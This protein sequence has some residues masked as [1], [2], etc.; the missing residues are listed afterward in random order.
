[1]QR[2]LEPQ[3]D[4]IMPAAAI[5]QGVLGLG[6]MIGGWIQQGKANEELGELDKNSPR[7]AQNQGI[8]D[9][10]NKALSRYNVSPTSSAMYKRQ[11]QN[12]QRGVATGIG[13][14]QDR[15]SGQAGISS[16]IRA[17]NDAMLNAEVAAENQ[18][19][20]RFGQL[21]QATGMK[22]GE[23]RM[24]FQINEVDPFER[25]YNRLSQKSGAGSQIANA[26]ISNVFG[27]LRNYADQQLMRD[28]YGN[29]DSGS[30]SRDR[31]GSGLTG[32][33]NEWLYKN[34][35]RKY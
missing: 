1:M 30:G 27:G 23:D 32:L 25:K 16:I 34:R 35:K 4:N 22:A 7:Y 29:S 17:S 3:N 8:M 21:G 20:Q 33:S 26:G 15:R 9:Y 14:L 13:A 18:Q 2:V 24:A 31:G 6:Q 10:Y 19:N 28:L 12:I 5:A 11:N